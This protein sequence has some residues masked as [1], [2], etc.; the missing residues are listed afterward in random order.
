[1]R[2]FLHTDGF[3]PGMP[4]SLFLHLMRA[5]LLRCLPRHQERPLPRSPSV[6]PCRSSV[7]SPAPPPRGF[8]DRELRQPAVYPRVSCVPSRDSAGEVRSCPSELRLCGAVRGCAVCA[9]RAGDRKGGGEIRRVWFWLWAEMHS[10]EADVG[11]FIP[12]VTSLSSRR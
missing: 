10:F 3:S 7:T 1:M 5:S 9:L 6:P 12:G 2:W 11:E 4:F 8:P